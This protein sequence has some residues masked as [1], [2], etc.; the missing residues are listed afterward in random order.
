MV[1]KRVLLIV[2]S[3]GPEIVSSSQLRE[4]A[5]LVIVLLAAILMFLFIRAFTL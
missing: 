1:G 2:L 5:D 4:S 3:Q